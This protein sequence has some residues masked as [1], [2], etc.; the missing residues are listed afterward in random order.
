LLVT[1]ADPLPGGPAGRSARR[2]HRRAADPPWRSGARR[3]GGGRPR[4]LRPAARRRPVDPRPGRPGRPGRPHRRFRRPGPADRRRPGRPAR[5]RAPARAEG[6]PDARARSVLPRGA[7]RWTRALDGV[8]ARTDLPAGF[9]ALA[10]LIAVVLGALQ[11]LAP[12]HGKTLMAT[13]AAARGGRA[14]L[15]DVL[16]MAASVTVTHT[17]GVVALGLLVAGG[18]AAAPSVVAWLGVAS[19]VLVTVAG[20]T[21]LR[22]ALRH[23]DGRHPH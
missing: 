16:P 6:E 11:A 10:L 1:R 3:A 15:R 4:R 18:S 19:G 21:L 17:L 9:A 23:R 2:P 7:D 5:A 13:T 20:A 8:V 12:G 14:R 22:R